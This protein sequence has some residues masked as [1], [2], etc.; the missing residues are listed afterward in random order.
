MDIE[1]RYQ[2]ALD[3]LYSFIDHS[4]TRNFRNSPDNF[5]LDRMRKMM[6]ILGNPQN[7]YKVIHVAGTKGKGS[8]S[9]FI[10]NV[11]QEAGYNVGFY[12]SPHLNDYCERIQVNQIKL[13]HPDFVDLIDEIRPFVELVE[14]ITTFELTTA[15]AFLYFFKQK[16]DYAVVEVGLG[17]RLDA[18]NIV[19]P[20]VSVIT[21]LS[22]D[23]INVLGDTLA[24][25]AYE[26]AGIIKPGKPVVISP[27]KEEAKR[28]LFRIAEERE[29][30]L[31]EV[32]EDFLY[33]SSAHN[34]DGQSF[35][36][37]S[38]DEQV[39]VSRF[40]ESSG[41]DEWVPKRFHIP[42]LGFHQ[43]QNAATAYAALQVLINSG[44]KITDQNISQG[45]HKV[46]WPGRFEV[47]S[48]KPMIVIDSAHNRESA[49]RL[50]LA[51]DDYFPGVP[52]TLIFGASEDKDI[53][54]MLAELL[55]RVKLVVATKSFHPR[56]LEPE[57][58]VE[59]ALKSG[60]RGYVTNSV[61]EAVDKAL[62]LAGNETIILVAGSLFVAA[63]VREVW[64]SN[65]N[66]FMI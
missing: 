3:Y 31:V 7:K 32:G 42:L 53:E 6:T 66:E 47:I 49:L 43:V 12:T 22:L 14:G 59:Y 33:A 51:I 46:V 54:G 39:A 9:A 20:V 5:D 16:I 23:H 10:A 37:W 34:L 30:E 36:V 65:S 40:I 26:K 27:Q 48:K 55:P 8:T 1:T 52:V 2:I 62:E 19:D 15:I 29:S 4:L 50:R 25:I 60:K 41:R 57:M 64:Y 11:L 44:T 38:K 61:E 21:S 13:S 63:A 24:K 28:V 58:I 56:A 18:T 35:F 17:G 45:F